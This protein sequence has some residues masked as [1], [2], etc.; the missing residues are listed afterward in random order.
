MSPR[1]RARWY[2]PPTSV[3]VRC[4]R[5]AWVVPRLCLPS[6]TVRRGSAAQ[7]PWQWLNVSAR[8]KAASAQSTGNLTAMVSPGSVGHV[9]THTPPLWRDGSYKEAGVSPSAP[10]SSRSP[11]AASAASAA[12]PWLLASAV[13]SL[14]FGVLSLLLIGVFLGITFS[15]LSSA[16]L[17]LVQCYV[18]SVVCGIMGAVLGHLARTHRDA[19]RHSNSAL[20]IAGLVLSYGGILVA[21]AFEALVYVAFALAGPFPIGP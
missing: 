2:R 9:D 15:G 4:E 17:P 11:Q 18:A 20:A 14:I 6:T 12:A 10:P 21:L 16:G 5:A 3:T 1:H 19:P 8:R 7:L 13:A